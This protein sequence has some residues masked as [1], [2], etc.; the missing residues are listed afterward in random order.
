MLLA[1]VGS[2]PISL[3]TNK[4][5]I[6]KQYAPYFML[7]STESFYPSSVEF[8]FNYTTRVYDEKY[9]WVLNTTAP[10][11][12]KRGGIN[13]WTHQ[14]FLGQRDVWKVPIYAY[15]LDKGYGITDLSYWAFF[16]FNHG[17]KV[18]GVTFGNHVGDWEHITIRLVNSQPTDI[19]VST[20]TSGELIPYDQLEK[21]NGRSVFYCSKGSHGFWKDPGNHIYYKKAKG[22]VK[23][24]DETDAGTEWDT[25]SNI[26]GFSWSSM[27]GIQSL[28]DDP[29]CPDKPNWMI[30][31]Q[32][33][34]TQ[35]NQV[36]SSGSIDFWGN[37]R[38]QSCVAGQCVLVSGPSGPLDKPIWG[39]EL[40]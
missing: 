8:H 9:G 32:R 27:S 13:Q 15:Y 19:Y 4:L 21:R 37:M 12:P 31:S 16:P 23:L 39:L 25:A 33:D 40:K 11:N 34:T 26:Q 10:L 7:H 2:F 5:E 24:I 3:A 28:C 6:L 29:Q 18:L 35:G 17:K 20:H 30:K 36:P 22:L 1:L 14:A 38:N